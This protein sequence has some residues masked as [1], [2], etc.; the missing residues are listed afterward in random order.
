MN[1]IKTLIIALCGLSGA[2]CGTL[3]LGALLLGRLTGGSFLLPVMSLFGSFFFRDKDDQKEDAEMERRR[4]R[5]QRDE[6]GIRKRRDPR[7]IDFDAAVDRY[8]GQDGKPKSG[9]RARPMP[10]KPSNQDLDDFEPPTLR[11]N[12]NR[13]RR[14]TRRSGRADIDDEIMGGLLD[15]DGD[16]F[17][18]S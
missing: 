11:S 6:G 15:D 2:C 5:R 8:A 18:D 12:R 7:D 9:G 13:P 10:R 14:D 17:P 3:V 4:P 1:D 16:G